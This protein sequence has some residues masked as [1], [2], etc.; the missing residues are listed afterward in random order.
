MSVSIR[1]GFNVWST[2]EERVTALKNLQAQ[3]FLTLKKEPW[4]E[5]GNCG[6][7]NPQNNQFLSQKSTTCAGC[8]KFMP[9]SNQTLTRYVVDGVNY[10][11]IKQ[12][13]AQKLSKLNCLEELEFQDDQRLWRCKVNGKSL[14]VF[15]THYSSYNPYITSG[16]SA[17]L[18]ISLDW[19]RDERS[20]HYYNSYQFAKFED[21][22]SGK[23]ELNSITSTITSTFPTN[24]TYQLVKKFEDFIASIEAKDFHKFENDFVDAFLKGIRERSKLLREYFDFLT[25]QKQTIVNSKTIFLGGSANADFQTISL[26]EYLQEGLRPGKV[27]EVKRYGTSHFT[28]DDFAKVML[29]ANGKDTLS[30]VSTNHISP[31]VWR[32]LIDAR[33]MERYYKHVIIDKDTILILIE[34]LGMQYLLP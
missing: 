4:Q 6:R 14:P 2:D 21:L 17:W 13:C 29:H 32:T 3:N 12:V 16:Q 15:I 19:E 8:G 23:A 22:L 11:K 33:N 26:L 5:C 30:I 10:N 24:P 7:P 9:L 18:C 25:L 28:V 31:E 20:T 34:A 1:S 27:G